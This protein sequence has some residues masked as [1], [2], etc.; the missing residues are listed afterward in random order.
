MSLYFSEDNNLEIMK[1]FV[2]SV[3]I[4][5]KLFQFRSVLSTWLVKLRSSNPARLGAPGLV[6]WF[7][8][9]SLNAP[10]ID[11]IQPIWGFAEHTED[12]RTHLQNTLAD[13]RTRYGVAKGSYHA[14]WV[15]SNIATPGVSPCFSPML[16]VR[17]LGRGHDTYSPLTFNIYICKASGVWSPGRYILDVTHEEWLPPQSRPCY[18]TTLWHTCTA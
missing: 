9:S 18:S 17:P 4:T 5:V 3:Y 1:L 15:R 13:C 6:A 11:D 14:S 12:C 8:Q 7:I 10:K 16:Y 2:T